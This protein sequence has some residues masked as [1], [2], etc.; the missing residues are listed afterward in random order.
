[1]IITV[2]VSRDYSGSLLTK[3]YLSRLFIWPSIALEL[4][5]M[6]KMLISKANNIEKQY[7]AALMARLFS[8]SVIREFAR[9]GKSSLFSRLIGELAPWGLYSSNMSVGELFDCAFGVLQKKDFRNEYVYKAAIAHKVLLGTHSLKSAVMINEFR[10][11]SCK[12]DTVILNGTST[13]YEIKSERD[14]LSRLEN[15]ISSYQD[16]F[17]KV[18]VIVGRNHLNLVL[19]SVPT[20]AGVLLLND[21]FQI[22]TIREAMDSPGKTKPD[23]IFDSIRLDEAKKI[24]KL[25][26]FNIPN[27]P[28]TLISQALK[29]DF[30]KLS[31][32]EA[33]HGM[34][35]VLRATRS[36]TSLQN[37]VS[38]LP[39]SIQQAVLSANLRKQDQARVINAINTRV[40]DALKWN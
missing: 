30:V 28:N 12:A 14:S 17:A 13:V 1:V 31:P 34:V 4:V 32:E 33:H 15:Q 26:G 3:K 7:L 23:S 36:M 25:Y 22:S 16:V 37:F 35:K 29:K 11:G 8:P 38:N 6:E 9:Q 24:L 40:S 2:F 5:G 39:L 20:E 27:L 19:S 10:V 21:R 18:N